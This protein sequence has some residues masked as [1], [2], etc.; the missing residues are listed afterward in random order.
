MYGDKIF[1][2]SVSAALIQLNHYYK[3]C[4][5]I[6]SNLNQKQPVFDCLDSVQQ[7]CISADRL[8]Y[9][10]AIEMVNIISSTSALIFWLFRY[11]S[12]ERYI[13]GCLSEWAIQFSWV[14]MLHKR[15]QIANDE[16][17]SGWRGSLH[18]KWAVDSISSEADASKYCLVIKFL[19]C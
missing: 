6:C 12:M 2:Y 13:S 8:I 16:G 14:I 5:L 10:H 17:I 3:E 7:P 4:L 9:I 11:I 18:F 15:P 1:E 19:L